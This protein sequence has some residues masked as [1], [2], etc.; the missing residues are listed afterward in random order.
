MKTSSIRFRLTVWYAGILTTVAVALAALFF[1]HLKNYL[2]NSLSEAQLRRGI[3]IGDTLISGSLAPNDNTIGSEISLLYAPEK[4][5]RFIRVTRPDG[6]VIYRSGVPNNQ[7]FDPAAV[8]IPTVLPA[9]DSIRIQPVAGSAALLV[10]ST[11]A[12]VPGHD[13][14]YLIEVGTSAAPVEVLFRHLLMILALGLPLVIVLAAAGGYALVRRALRPVDEITNKAEQITQHN[15]GE[16]LPVPTTGDELERLSTSLNHMIVRLDDAFQNSKRFVADASHE[17]RTPLTILSGELEH[18]AQDKKLSRDT[19]ER[20]GSLLEEVARLVKIVE[21]LFALSR[22]DAG[23]AQSECV[24]FDLAALTRVTAE[25][26]MLLAEDRRILV[27]CNASTEVRVEGDRSRLKQVIVNLLDN[28]IK[29]TPEGGAVNL[30]VQD[31][32]GR[33]VLEVADTGVGISNDD[34]G[35]VF[36]RFFRADK[37]RSRNPD[38]A[39]LGLSIV[40]SICHAHNGTAEVESVLGNGSCFRISLPKASGDTPRTNTPTIL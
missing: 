21:R 8:P 40:R 3:Q 24:S 23:E 29:Y 15:L 17:L 20:L 18:L 1:L 14:F 31:D 10:A 37:N 16:R 6:K 4:S 2:E 30:T 9:S 12:A 26:M 5:D 11:R 33:A 34:L 13:G 39:G 32:K 28:A 25:Q 22:L 7:A 27:S 19:R 35:R 38:G 36:G